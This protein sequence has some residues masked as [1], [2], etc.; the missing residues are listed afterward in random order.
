MKIWLMR[1]E[2]FED[3]SIACPVLLTYGRDPREAR[4]LRD[5]VQSLA[6]G[7]SNSDLQVDA[8][9]GFLGVHGCSLIARLGDSDRGVERR[10]DSGAAFVCELSQSGWKNV[11]GLLEPF[12]ERQHASTGEE[13]QYL[14]EAGS[15]EWIIST[16]RGW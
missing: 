5:A 8:L 10:P 16:S 4:L 9:P 1:L 6:A 13:F 12:A 3:R 7:G 14:S 15:I 2:Y 11:S